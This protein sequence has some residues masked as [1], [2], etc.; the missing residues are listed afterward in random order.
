LNLTDLQL[1]GARARFI[2]LARST[3]DR[4]F[5]EDFGGIQPLK[6]IKSIPF[7]LVNAQYRLGTPEK[8]RSIAAQ[9]VS[10]I[11]TR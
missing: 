3:S 4:Q 9:I 7:C 8:A 6:E 11:E 2:Q 10:A 5:I 1:I